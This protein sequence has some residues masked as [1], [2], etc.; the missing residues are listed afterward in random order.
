MQNCF[1]G[2]FIQLAQL[3]KGHV[4]FLCNTKQAVTFL[5]DIIFLFAFLPD[6]NRFALGSSFLL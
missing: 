1:R 4:V 6:L 5:D 2:D 3:I